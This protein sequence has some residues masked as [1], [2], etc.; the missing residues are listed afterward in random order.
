M[1][2]LFP[3]L[4]FASLSLS[5]MACD[6]GITVEKTCGDGFLDPGEECDGAAFIASDCTELGYYIQL[7][8][9]LC[10]ANCTIDTSACRGRCGDGEIQTA[11]EDC[12]GTNLDGLS[13]QG[14][15]YHGG[16]LSCGADC[17]H[18]LTSCENEGR[19]GDGV[20]QAPEETCDGEALGGATCA[21]QGFYEGDVTCSTECALDFSGCVGSCGD[22]TIQAGREDCEGDDLGGMT[23]ESLGYH[24]GQLAC[25]PSP[26]AGACTFDLTSC[27]EAGRCG[28]GVIDEGLEECDGNNLSDATCLDIGRYVGSP[29]CTASCWL[30][31]S[32]CEDFCGDGVLDHEFESCDGADLGPTNCEVLGYYQGTP[33]CSDDCSTVLT[34]TCSGT[35]GDGVS[36]AA[37]GEQC[38]GDDLSGQTCQSH[39]F[40]VGPLIC[41]SSTC[42]TDDRQ[43]G[44]H[45]RITAGGLHSCSVA[46][47]GSPNNVAYCWGYGELGQLGDNTLSGRSSPARVENLSGI[48][49]IE[50]G[51]NHTCALTTLGIYCWGSGES[52]QLGIGSTPQEQGAPLLVSSLTHPITA[53]SCGNDHTCAIRNNLL[54]C[55][56]YNTA[57]QIG[58]GSNTQRN[59]PVW[60]DLIAP[61]VQVS[62]G[63]SHTCVRLSNSD[64]QCWGAGTYGQL[65]RG[66]FIGASI[67]GSV[68]SG[69]AGYEDIS[70][71]TQHTCGVR[72]GRIWCWGRNLERQSGL[73]ATDSLADPTD[74][75]ISGVASVHCGQSHT[76]ALKTDGTVVCWGANT[77]GQTGRSDSASSHVPNTVNL[78]GVTA[79]AVGRNHNCA[80]VTDGRVWCWG[81]NWERQLG[82]L[83]TAAPFSNVPVLVSP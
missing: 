52:G 25:V 35:C 53:I 19:C 67:P 74:T 34:G 21:G 73:E 9:L 48:Q 6:D 4:F 79:L 23:C 44:N 5:L 33:S 10:T 70:S 24:G 62:A 20:I 39:G 1:K 36:Q 7:G 49:I 18:D 17:R 77:S 45:T 37:F 78:V 11:H 65:G 69:H 27:E 75:G 26:G 3:A 43:C 41:S 2:I 68:G 22:G 31:F 38:D 81:N 8:D 15:G 28:D 13:C 14:L 72:S 51:G 32:A 29:T 59:L 64:V 54:Y 16:F 63:G 42:Q 80:L 83:A 61:P 50:G 56:G 71:G 46:T 82:D 40:A 12:D 66:T 58:D 60:V 47:T 55:W 57:G 76:C 30:D